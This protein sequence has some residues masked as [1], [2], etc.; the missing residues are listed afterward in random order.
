MKCTMS[1]VK[2]HSNSYKKHS[3]NQPQTT[4]E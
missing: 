2:Q 4:Y 1:W 3:S